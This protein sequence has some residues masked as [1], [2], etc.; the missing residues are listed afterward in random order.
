MKKNIILSEAQRN[1][2]ENN[3]GLI[4]YALKKIDIRVIGDMEDAYQ[5]G[6]IG[7]IKAA[8]HYDAQRAVSFATFAMPC[9]LNELRME[10]RRHNTMAN[11][12][13]VVSLDA[14]IPGVESD[15]LTLA[16]MIADGD[17]A[18][19]SRLIYQDTR[20]TI[21]N[22]ARNAEDKDAMLLLRMM[23]EGVRQSEM[24][25]KL[26]CSQ[27]YVSGKQKRIREAIRQALLEG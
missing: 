25:E 9:I 12:A 19:D 24:A 20:R 18:M 2:V 16:D 4:G 6:S 8:Y 5:I 17:P 13:V 27:S 22:T 1:L 21:Q 15:T 26:G 7:L 10:K 23:I 14:P 11:R 3:L